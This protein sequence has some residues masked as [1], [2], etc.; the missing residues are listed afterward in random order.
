MDAEAAEANG[1]ADAVRIVRALEIHALTGRPASELRREWADPTPRFPHAL[2]VLVAPRD[3]LRERIAARTGA[4]L[5]SG[6]IE[7]TAALLAQGIPPSAHCFKALGYREIIEHLDGRLTRAALHDRIVT[8]TAQF[9]RRQM[10]W[11]RRE[12]PAIWLDSATAARTLDAI[13]A[14]ADAPV[15]SDAY[16]ADLF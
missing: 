2:V 15:S 9:A 6:W 14:L 16:L 4:M 5:E 7:E 10:I 12:R 3:V 8:L 13:A 1:S 11:L